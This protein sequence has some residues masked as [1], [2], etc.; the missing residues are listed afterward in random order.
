MEKIEKIHFSNKQKKYYDYFLKELN[1]IC[2][3]LNENSNMNFKITKIENKVQKFLI[4]IFILFCYGKNA[5]INSEPIFTFDI[6]QIKTKEEMNYYKFRNEINVTLI[7][8]YCKYGFSYKIIIP[9]LKQSIINSK[10]L[11]EFGLYYNKILYFLK[12]KYYWDDCTYLINYFTYFNPKDF[13]YLISLI[14]HAILFNDDDYF[15]FFDEKIMKYIYHTLYCNSLEFFL[16]IFNIYINNNILI[17]L[18]N[19]FFDKLKIFQYKKIRE[20]ALLIYFDKTRKQLNEKEKTF[21]FLF[22]KFN[23]KINKFQNKIIIIK[24]ENQIKLNKKL[25]TIQN[26]INSIQKIKNEL[27]SIISLNKKISHSKSNTI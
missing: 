10:Y 20:K 21:N 18:K 27:F 11:D 16:F 7:F 1:L 15:Y 14:K 22:N 9:I 17:T 5:E 19:I 13:P 25:K 8:C 23:T 3:S 2:L 26:E 6:N 12:K 4:D 24:N